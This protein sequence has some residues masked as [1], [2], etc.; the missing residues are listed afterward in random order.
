MSTQRHNLEEESNVP[1]PAEGTEGVVVL[2]PLSDT[3]GPSSPG[4]V[5]AGAS[6]GG[7]LTG[8]GVGATVVPQFAVGVERMVEG[9]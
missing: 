7:V 4:P 5:P 2:S 8:V 1:P 9:Q 6:V 3:G